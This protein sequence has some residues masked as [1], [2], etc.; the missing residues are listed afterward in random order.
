MRVGLRKFGW[1]GLAQVL[2]M[3]IRLASNLVLTRL[4][5]PEA[6][7]LFG[8]AIAWTMTLAM[9][10]D[11]GVTPALMRS[12]EGM[13]PRYL[14]TG[15]S[16]NLARGVVAMLIV[17]AMA[18][19]VAA[20]SRTPALFPVLAALSLQCLLPTLQ[21]PGLPRVRRALDY[22]GLFYLEV[23]Q[24]VVA[25]L[26][27]VALAWATRSLWAIVGGMF[28]GS[29]T[30]IVIS[31]RLSPMAPRWTWDRRVVREIS[32]LSRQ[33][34]VN[35]LVMALWMNLDRL[36]GLRYVSLEQMGCYS[37][38]LNLATIIDSFA[39]RAS[40]VYFSMLS[41]RVEPE[42]RARWHRKFGTLTAAFVMP[43]MAVAIAVSPWV[44]RLLYDPRYAPAAVLLAILC[45]RSAVQVVCQT[46][47]RYLLV[48]GSIWINTL[49]YALGL[50]TQAALL[51]PLTR[52][53]GARGMAV[54]CLA[55][56]LVYGGVQSA[57]LRLR[58]DGRL[59]PFVSAVACIALGLAV[60]LNL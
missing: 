40:D 47:F 10:T 33:V 29:L 43:A 48:Q 4:L 52:A 23:G 60:A 41:Q 44:V 12:P 45:G 1:T 31:Y 36:L 51:I 55:S 25:T 15:W 11:L 5:A 2:G 16:M 56:M 32:R 38:A 57:L 13:Q 50:A 3:G 18:W 27:S 24:T 37:V 53:H 14:L 9:M 26:T 49:A 7:G 59:T 54:A 30:A 17:V 8:T 34:F 21:S 22:R 28:A 35:T 19:P 42:E 39:G 46:Q 20:A 6:Y 58:G